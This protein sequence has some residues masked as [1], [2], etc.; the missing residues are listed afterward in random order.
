MPHIHGTWGHYVRPGKTDG[1]RYGTQRFVW[2]DDSGD[3]WV[4][5]CHVYDLRGRS[6]YNRPSGSSGKLVKFLKKCLPETATKTVVG[7]VGLTCNLRSLGFESR[8]EFKAWCADGMRGKQ[9]SMRRKAVP[10]SQ[11]KKS[12][13]AKG[14]HTS[15]KTTPGYGAPGT[16]CTNGEAPNSG[17]TKRRR[18]P[19]KYGKTFYVVDR[20]WRRLYQCMLWRSEGVRRLVIDNL[21]ADSYTIDGNVVTITKSLEELGFDSA[22]AFARWCAAAKGS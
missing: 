1:Y 18:M 15:T 2:R 5:H 13:S 12:G 21:P 7:G 17:C 9:R 22:P 4:A 11:L 14:S 19:A 10:K 16:T 3:V 6:L 8:E 20:E